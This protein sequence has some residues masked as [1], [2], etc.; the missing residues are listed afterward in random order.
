MHKDPVASAS[1]SGQ[2]LLTFG[3]LAQIEPILATLE[4]AVTQVRNGRKCLFQALALIPPAESQ[5]EGSG[6]SGVVP[7][8]GYHPCSH[9]RQFAACLSLPVALARGTTLS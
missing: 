8:A 6:S 4:F 5:A 9:E 1:V 7:F 2:I 3:G